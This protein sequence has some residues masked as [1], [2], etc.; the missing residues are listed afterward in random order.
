[1]V[2]GFLKPLVSAALLTCKFRLTFE[3]PF[4]FKIKDVA[5]FLTG[6]KAHRYVDGPWARAPFVCLLRLA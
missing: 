5:A 3:F 1:M 6:T 2:G 4:P